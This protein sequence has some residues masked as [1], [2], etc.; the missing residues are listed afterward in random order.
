M[1]MRAYG[2]KSPRLCVSGWHAVLGVQSGPASSAVYIAFKSP[3]PETVGSGVGFFTHIDFEWRQPGLRASFH[4]SFGAV[5]D[6]E[7]SRV[8]TSQRRAASLH[9]HPEPGWPARALPGWV[10]TPGET[11]RRVAYRTEQ[12]ADAITAVTAA[13]CDISVRCEPPWKTVIFECARWAM[14]SSD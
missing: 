7:R 4:H 8:P 12:M 3:V 13:G 14:N 2:R 9:Q 10:A 5:P 6:L 1:D 11:T